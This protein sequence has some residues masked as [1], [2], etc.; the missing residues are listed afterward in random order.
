MCRTRGDSVNCYLL[1]CLLLSKPNADNHP[2]FSIPW[3]GQLSN[4]L[5]ADNIAP[6]FLDFTTPKDDFNGRKCASRFLTLWSEA[7]GGQKETCGTTSSPFVNLITILTNPT[8][9]PIAVWVAMGAKFQ[10]RQVKGIIT[11]TDDRWRRRAS[12]ATPHRNG[13][14]LRV[15]IQ[16]LNIFDVEI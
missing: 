11:T 2:W 6:D 4:N 16:V 8:W 15:L 12:G 9:L 5:N 1:Q 3:W 14:T 10:W 7:C 13:F